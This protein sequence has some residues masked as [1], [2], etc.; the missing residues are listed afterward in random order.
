[1]DTFYELMSQKYTPSVYTEIHVSQSTQTVNKSDQ[2]SDTN[3]QK[4][5]QEFEETDPMTMRLI[6]FKKLEAQKK[7]QGI[8]KVIED[9]YCVLQDALNIRDISDIGFVCLHSNKKNIESKKRTHDELFHT[10]RDV[11]IQTD[12]TL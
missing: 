9:L 12:E 8:E 2:W 11:V 1:M 4:E 6:R 3:P 7:E 10:V 5:S